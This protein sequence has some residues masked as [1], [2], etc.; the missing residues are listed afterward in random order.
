MKLS[1][2]IAGTLLL[3]TLASCASQNQVTLEAD[4]YQAA[5]EYRYWST[6]VPGSTELEEKGIDLIITLHQWH[7]D[8]E[9]LYAVFDQRKSFLPVV[10]KHDNSTA[11]ITARII[12]ESH[13]IDEFSEK[14]ELSDRLVYRRSD[15]SEHYFKISKKKEVLSD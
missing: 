15:G 14:T 7:E 4:N 6:P 2:I 1:F 9:P 12:L 5:A 13:L 3:L 8:Y 11:V 10:T